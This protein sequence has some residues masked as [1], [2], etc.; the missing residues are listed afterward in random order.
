MRA[1]RPKPS[2]AVLPLVGSR[3]LRGLPVLVHEAFQA[4][5]GS[6]TT[7]DRGKNSRYRSARVAFRQCKSISVLIASFRGSIPSPPVPL[8]TLRHTPHGV[9]RKTRGRAVR[10]SFLVGLLHSL[11]HAGLSRRTALAILRS[12]RSIRPCC[13]LH[14]G[15][16]VRFSRLLSRQR[17]SAMILLASSTMLKISIPSK[18]C[19]MAVML[20]VHWTHHRAA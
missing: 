15:E 18:V 3:H 14:L 6:T 17:I 20:R 1:L 12:A 19:S 16:G 10:Y 4:C 11:L 13:S 8:F 2:P 9:R 5:L 7:Q